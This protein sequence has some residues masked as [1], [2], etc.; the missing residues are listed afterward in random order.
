LTSD[1]DGSL[2]RLRLAR[3]TAQIRRREADDLPWIESHPPDRRRLLFDTTVY[4]DIGLGKFPQDAQ[5]AVRGFEVWHSTVAESELAY[6]CGRFDPK[7]PSTEQ[8][9]EEMA[10]VV[11]KWPQNRVLTPDR[12]IWREAA[13]LS[14]ILARL[15]HARAEERGR[16]MNDALIF[17]SA[18]KQGCAVLS[19][20]LR[21][22]DLLMQLVPEG[23][24]VFYRMH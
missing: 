21:D 2:R 18:V 3:A 4:V 20:N 10:A 7:H 16:T 15:Q 8:A 22:F 24:A 17:L 6:L 12:E 1:F 14:G 9:V 5:A 23:R 13:I 11:R 19:R